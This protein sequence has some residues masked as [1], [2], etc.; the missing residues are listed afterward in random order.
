MAKNVARD[1]ERLQMMQ[2]NNKELS[3]AVS[4]MQSNNKELSFAVSRM[5][6][7]NKELSSAVSRMQSAV[8]RMKSAASAVPVR[9]DLKAR[10][11]LPPS[12]IAALPYS[13][14][15]PA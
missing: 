5:K 9:E 6:E 2:S 10:P 14:K 15:P 13:T 11:G 1:T 12:S 3:S 8:S 7:N 4:R